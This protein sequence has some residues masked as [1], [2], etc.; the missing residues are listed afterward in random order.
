M[1]TLRV[2]FLAGCIGL[3]GLVSAVRAQ[4]ETS[5]EE[6]LRAVPQA[7][8]D[9]YLFHTKRL[10]AGYGFH[11]YRSHEDKETQL[12]D[13][14]VRGAGSATAFQD[15]LSPRRLQDLQGRLDAA[16]P[17]EVYYQLRADR[18]ASLRFAFTDT[19]LARQLG[20]L[21]VDDTAP[22]Q[23]EVTYRVVFVDANG[24]PTGDEMTASAQLPGE[25]P[26]S[27]TD[28]AAEHDAEELTLSWSYSTTTIAIPDNV[29]SFRVYRRA[30]SGRRRL[31]PGR[32]LL[33]RVAK[34]R[35]SVTIPVP[36][37]GTHTFVATAVD[38]T[39][40]ESPASEPL[41]YTVED[42]TP[43]SPPSAVRV[44]MTGTAAATLTWAMAPEPDAAGYHVYRA[45]RMVEDGERLTEEPI[46]LDRRTYVDSTLAG[47]GK[48]VYRVT[49]IDSAGN[50]SATSR[51]AQAFVNDR[52]PPSPPSSI[53]ARFDSTDGHVQLSWTH[54]PTAEDFA[55]Y[56]LVRTRTDDRPLYSRLDTT[57][58]R[59]SRFLDQ[60]VA[61][62]GLAEGARYRYGV[63]AVDSAGNLSDTTFVDLKVPNLT[64]PQAPTG[65]SA[66]SPDGV[67]V[68]LRWRAPP[69]QSVTTYRVYRSRGDSLRIP[70]PSQDTALIDLE[71]PTT[72]Y[73]DTT[74]AVG[75][76]Y[77]YRVT[78]VDSLGREG[79]ASSQTTFTLRDQAPPRPVRNV[80]A[81]AA[82]TIGTDTI[83]TDTTGVR[84][85]WGRVAADDLDGYRIYRASIPTGTYEP[86]QRVNPETTS[87]A[88]PDGTVGLW[89]QVRTLDTSGNESQP[90]EPAQ[91]V[92]PERTASQ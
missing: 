8:G 37:P 16:S 92:R 88:D 15:A 4:P 28:L 84:I 65:L 67:D 2:L 31:A 80:R 68:D 23:G 29:V 3:F 69:V 33:R 42:Q 26:D 75:Q 76:T 34:S 11:V 70:T 81:L 62:Q 52:T 21:F 50:E 53:R 51:G 74:A 46:P 6:F 41:R 45:P 38:I 30:E 87:W 86:V 18:I 9:V 10:P 20:Y 49:A 57:A 32:I 12:T 7:D 85:V 63:A 64:A 79:A 17:L 66:R 43:P 1:H 13:T 47:G 5:M 56:A 60:G 40:Q 19:T 22:G 14:P 48:F 35:Q 39:G 54:E 71:V 24:D 90:S 91:A 77:T 44:R 73:E 55:S 27:P 61:G 83:G 72:F 82:D 25:H 89:Y 78:A 58:L 36:D 59:R